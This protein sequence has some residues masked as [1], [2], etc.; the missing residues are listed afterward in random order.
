MLRIRTTLLEGMHTYSEGLG[1][2]ISHRIINI[3]IAQSRSEQPD[4]GPAFDEQQ[5]GE[6]PGA[7][8]DSSL[9]SRMLSIG[10]FGV[11]GLDED[12]VA[13]LPLV[14]ASWE[15]DPPPGGQSR[16]FSA[17][18]HWMVSGSH[19]DVAGSSWVD[20]LLERTPWTEHR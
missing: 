17:R 10:L 11:E 13:E 9:F 3:A 4:S 12:V 6:N 5:D 20:L 16:L 8:I 7:S 2:G 14:W 18:S 15:E 19:F 1:V